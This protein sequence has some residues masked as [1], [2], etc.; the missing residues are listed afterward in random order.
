MPAVALT[1]V[2]PPPLNE[3]SASELAMLLQHVETGVFPAGACICK[4]GSIGDAAF[5]LDRGVARVQ[6]DRVD[7]TASELDSDDVVGYVE[8]GS[9]FGELA[10]LDGLPRSASVYAQTEVQVRRISSEALAVVQAEHP[11]V[12]ARI[13]AALGRSA[14]LK[15]RDTTSR[16]AQA[17][18]ADAPDPEVE[19][20][21]ARA[22]VA[23]RTIHDWSE[24]RIDRLLLAMAQAI[25]ERAEQLARATVEETR[26]GDI[27]SKTVKNRV[28]SL[29]VYRSLAGQ[30]G[31]GTIA[32]NRWRGV[33]EIA[34]PVGVVFGLIPVTNPVATFIFKALICVKGRNA[35]IV[36]PNRD[37]LGVSISV[38]DLLKDVLRK[39]GAP[40]DLLQCV[41][42]RTSRKKTAQF[43]THPDVALIL[44]TGGASM[45]K[46]AYS[47]GKPA[48]GVG[49]GNTP[50]LVC[51]DANPRKVAQDVIRSKTFDN[52]LLCG[53]EH[54][55]VVVQ[56][57]R[58]AFVAALE[59]H[60]AAVLGPDEVAAFSKH[61]VNPSTGNFRSEIIGQAA[62]V[63][64]ARAGIE[65][66]YPIRLVVVPSDRVAASNP[67]AREK[68]APLLGLFT[69]PDDDAGIALCR[70]LLQVDGLGHTAVIHTRSQALADRF[71]R[72]MPASR[73]LVNSPASL[74]IA[75][76]TTGLIPSFTLGCGTFGGTSTTDNVTFT[77]LVNVKRLARFSPQVQSLIDATVPF[78]VRIPRT[79]RVLQAGLA[80][81][82]ARVAQR[83]RLAAARSRVT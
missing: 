64:A 12:A 51:S 54:N 80:W 52:G 24:E 19:E 82:R 3:L 45:V 63:I 72:E 21:V 28:S 79:V 60:G 69:V 6:L 75:G 1:N 31:T 74:G 10:L 55:L 71:G 38:E 33:T 73:I 4:V 66:A 39:H 78:D 46:S 13:Y 30:P 56:A 67:F 42:Q 22:I 65:R 68:M 43:M 58:Q 49:P 7:L 5:I 8:A 25:A 23:Q 17:I 53:S 76:L 16:L 40:E 77:H 29:V 18:F 34:S 2:L 47:S 44:A 48:I 57:Q 9:I 20:M 81:A 62:A 32:R 37:A 50:T 35:L 36:S 59:Q 70:A 61:L 27:E 41:R 26:I 14:A 11:Q 15:L 83:W